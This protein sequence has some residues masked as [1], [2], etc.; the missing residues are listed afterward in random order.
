MGDTVTTEV[1]FE[2]EESSDGVVVELDG[3]SCAGR[4]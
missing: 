4:E 3:S 2:V 1:A